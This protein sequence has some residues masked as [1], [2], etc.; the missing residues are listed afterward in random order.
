MLILTP[1]LT[2]KP[3]ELCGQRQTARTMNRR[4]PE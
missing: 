1:G 2:P 4:F 3:L